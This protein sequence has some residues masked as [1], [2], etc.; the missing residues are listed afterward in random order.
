MNEANI[1][2]NIDMD[3]LR[4][5]FQEYVDEYSLREVSEPLPWVDMKSGDFKFILKRWNSEYGNKPKEIPAESQF[6]IFFIRDP[7]KELTA[8]RSNKPDVF[9]SFCIRL[10]KFGYLSIRKN[11][12]LPGPAKFF[13]LYI[14]KSKDIAVYESVSQ[15]DKYQTLTG[16]EYHED[17]SY[18]SKFYKSEYDTLSK[19]ICA[20]YVIKHHLLNTHFFLCENDGLSNAAPCISIQGKYKSFQIFRK[21]DEWFLVDEFNTDDAIFANKSCIHYKCDQVDGLTDLLRDKGA[22]EYT[23][24]ESNSDSTDKFLFEIEDLL[25]EYIDKYQM[26]ETTEILNTSSKYGNKYQLSV[27]PRG[28]NILTIT[29]DMIDSEINTYIERLKRFEYGCKL[30]QPANHKPGKASIIFIDSP[31]DELI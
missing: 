14:Y 4:D 1:N 28:Y 27:A 20:G 12:V 19:L 11:I 16:K 8:Q 2:Q 6:C 9:T 21:K 18:L 23:I 13:Y 22:I 31:I 26:K 15:S 24:N 3:L 10:E 25:Q 29:G 17:F 7:N 30:I 5:L